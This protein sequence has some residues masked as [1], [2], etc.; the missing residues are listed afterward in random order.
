[1]A[2]V[3]YGVRAHSRR[4]EVILRR[5]LGSVASASVA[6]T[7]MSGAAASGTA[8]CVTAPCEAGMERLI[9]VGP[10]RPERC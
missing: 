5:P 8:M 9:P 1:M 3:K 6:P 4:H 10:V 7:V 2:A